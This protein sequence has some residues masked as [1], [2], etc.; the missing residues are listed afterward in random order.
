MSSNLDKL[1]NTASKIKTPLTLSGIVIVVLYAI[2]RQVLSLDVFEKIGSNSTFILL[3]NILDKLFWLALFAIILG[4]ISYLTIFILGRKK[5]LTSSS[6]VLI[7]ASLDPHDSPYQQTVENGRK[8]IRPKKTIGKDE[9]M[10][11]EVANDKYR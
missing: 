9:I 6:V 3:Q 4:V 7:D 5:P 1:M 2:Y 11:R 10:L 8:T